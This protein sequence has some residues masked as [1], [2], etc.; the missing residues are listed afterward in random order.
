MTVTRGL[1]VVFMVVTIAAAVPREEKFAELRE[2]GNPNPKQEVAARQ[3]SD[4]VTV[5]GNTTG[6]N[7]TKPDNETKP[8][9]VHHGL[10]LQEVKFE[11]GKV[12]TS[13]L[14]DKNHV[15]EAENAFTDS[16]DYW[17]S[18][19]GKNGKGEYQ[20]F[21]H[22][23]WYDF[24]SRQIVPGQ[25]GIRPFS[26]VNGPT[27]W[28]FIGSNDRECGRYSAWEILCS[29]WSGKAIEQKQDMKYCTVDEKIKGSFRCLGI[30]ALNSKRK[31]D[32]ITTIST[33]RMWANV[34]S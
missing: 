29:D 18:G 25:V 26:P 32:P 17:A 12:G 31:G 33:I 15:H 27:M 3:R 22:L 34:S 2:A 28:D 1:A 6:S 10:V 9:N 8:D 4:N 11:G 14:Y 19:H 5:A 24:V 7:V 20:M 23:I 16:D 30:R 21:P 13:S